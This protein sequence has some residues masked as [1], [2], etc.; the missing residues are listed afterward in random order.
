MVSL[1][2]VTAQS[3]FFPSLREAM[4]PWEPAAREGEPAAKRSQ[5]WLFPHEG[6][7]MW[8]KPLSHYWLRFLYLQIESQDCPPHSLLSAHVGPAPCFDF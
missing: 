2:V 8:S 6:C 7:G 1:A 3:G 4:V 5:S